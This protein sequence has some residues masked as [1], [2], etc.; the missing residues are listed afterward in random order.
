MRYLDEI[1]TIASTEPDNPLI[2]G[3]AL[4]TG[5]EKGV[6]EAIEEYFMSFPIIDEGHITEGK[7]TSSA[8]GIRSGNPGR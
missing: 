1:D 3:T 8:W 6:K 4:H 2:V 7:E 5:I